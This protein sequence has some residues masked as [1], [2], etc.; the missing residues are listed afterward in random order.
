MHGEVDHTNDFRQVQFE[1]AK[2]IRN[3]AKYPKPTDVEARRMKIYSELFYNNVE[4]FMATAY[5]VLCEISG[6]E[7]WHRMIRDYFEKHHSAT[8]LFPEMPREFLKYLEN[9]REAEQD[10]FPF[11]LELA[12]Y[13][14]VE[15]A[16]S[17]TD[18]ENDYNNIDPEG[19]LLEGIPVLSNT[20]WPLSYNFAVHKIGPDYLP[21]QPETQPTYIIVYRDNEDDVMF[22]EIN[23]VTAQLMQ[24]IN[25]D[26]KMT[27]RQML[28]AIAEQLNHPDP[29]VVIQG[30]LQILNDLKQRNV[31]IGVNKS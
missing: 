4:S 14:W 19:D 11:M 24:Y 31:I 15:L 16:L 6:D 26:T 29:E 27:G 10:D 12:H 18:A 5:P 20:A 17:V 22:L 30:G 13:E 1:F 28:G 2:H 9:E 21:E 25:E 3:P 8:P 7:K 23:P